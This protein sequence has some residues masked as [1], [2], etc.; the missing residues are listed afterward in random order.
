[1]SDKAEINKNCLNTIRLLAAIQVLY[2]HTLSHLNIELPSNILSNAIDFLINFFDGVPIFFTL[3]GFLI[4]HS[5][6]RSSTFG[7]YIKK[8]FWRIY[9]ELWLAVI[10]ELAVIIILYEKPI[11]WAQFGLFGVTQGTIFQ[12]WTPEFLRNYGCG[13]PN[14]SLWTICVLIQFYFFAYFIYRALHNKK[15]YKW[16]IAISGSLA[17]AYLSPIIS[18]YMP[19][20]VAKLY[21]QTLFPYLWLFIIAAFA[22]EKRDVIMPFVK[23]NWWAFIILAVIFNFT[24]FDIKASYYIF[25]TITLFAGLLG[26]S[27]IFPSINIKTDISYGIYI[28]HMTVVNALITLGYKESLWQLFVVL[29]ITCILAY[30]STK[31]VGKIS[32][33]AKM[34]YNK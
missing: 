23:K 19:E 5:I 30:I 20:T 3:S 31:S 27:Y 26:A 8:R 12:F 22:A 15:N 4:W 9:P 34:K 11:N 21:K 13:C 14:G 2:M 32:M 7:Q 16:V 29:A 1:M 6:G 24:R 25:G 33:N 18:S 28:Y 10:I 17:I